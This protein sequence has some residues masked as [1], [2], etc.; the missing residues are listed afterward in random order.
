MKYSVNY[1]KP[2]EE[3]QALENVNFEAGISWAGKCYESLKSTMVT[4]YAY[5]LISLYKPKGVAHRVGKT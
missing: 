1:Y 3:Y 2:H 4:H 5:S